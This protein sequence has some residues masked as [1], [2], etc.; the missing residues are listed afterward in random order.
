MPVLVG[1]SQSKAGSSAVAASWRSILDAIPAGAYTC[2]AAGLLTYFNP[3]AEGVWGRV[4]KLRD[5]ADRYCGSFK[6]YSSNGTRM[7]HE[8]CWMAL[9]LQE[10]KKYNGREVVIEQPGGGR[11][12]AMAYANPL[13][14][15]QG[16]IIGAVNLVLDITAQKKLEADRRKARS[17]VTQYHDATLAMIEVGVAA[18]TSARWEPS[19]FS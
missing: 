6:L 8:A 11:I 16:Q 2:D 4:P 9:A 13:H 15:N 12:F 10:G 14:D 5:P 7:P 3:L 1:K 19:A 17:I 18:L